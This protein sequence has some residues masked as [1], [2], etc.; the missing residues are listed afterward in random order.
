EIQSEPLLSLVARG[1]EEIEAPLRLKIQACPS[2]GCGVDPSC[3]APRELWVEIERAFYPGRL[4][5]VFIP[6][7]A[8]QSPDE[9]DPAQPN[10]T[11]GRCEVAGCFW[12]ATPVWCFDAGMGPHFC[13]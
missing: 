13:E 4:T 8:A 9:A 6:L 12:G 7:D 2:A 5:S 3:P 10:L 1:Q 11:V